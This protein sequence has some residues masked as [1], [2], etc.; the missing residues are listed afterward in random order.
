MKGEAGPGLKLGTLGKLDQSRELSVKENILS[1]PSQ[2]LH[3]DSEE[4]LLR[5]Y[6]FPVER[7]LMFFIW[8]SSKELC[9]TGSVFTLSQAVGFPEVS[10]SSRFPI[11][12]WLPSRD[13]EITLS[14]W[15]PNLDIQ[16]LL[17]SRFIH[18]IHKKF[19]YLILFPHK[20]GPRQVL[21][22]WV[23]G[24]SHQDKKLKSSSTSSSCASTL[25]GPFL[26]SEEILDSTVVASLECCPLYQLGLTSCHHS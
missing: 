13:L 7:N 21:P 16:Y 20:P 2:C 4:K 18:V 11:G 10:T 8:V 9:L 19:Q 1:V 15:A 17:L 25:H 3:C 24:W 12:C 5:T 26:V 23:D 22:V 14:C 6:F